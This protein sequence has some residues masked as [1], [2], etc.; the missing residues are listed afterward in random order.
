MAVAARNTSIAWV[1]HRFEVLSKSIIREYA[2]VS[3][4]ELGALKKNEEEPSGGTGR[5]GAH[6]RNW[7]GLPRKQTLAV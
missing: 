5:T 2:N 1:V 3:I 6:C 4:T 7:Q